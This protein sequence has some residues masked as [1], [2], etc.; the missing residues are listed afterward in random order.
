M[1]LIMTRGIY[2]L[3]NLQLQCAWGSAEYLYPRRCHW[4]ELIY[5]FRLVS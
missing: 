3:I 5:A 4:A 1:G 2:G